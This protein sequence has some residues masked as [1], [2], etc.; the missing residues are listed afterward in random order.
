MQ[1]ANGPAQKRL[2]SFSPHWSGFP[3]E[4]SWGRGGG[5]HRDV[6][7]FKHLRSGFKMFNSMNS[8]LIKKTPKFVSKYVNVIMHFVVFKMFPARLSRRLLF[9]GLPVDTFGLRVPTGP[10]KM[11]TPVPGEVGERDMAMSAVSAALPSSL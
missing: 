8:F 3:R 4:W 9:C 5:R 11:G 10:E 2:G 1:D 6:F 7:I